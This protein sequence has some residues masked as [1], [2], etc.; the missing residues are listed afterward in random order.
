MKIEKEELA[1]VLAQFNPWWRSEMI[2]DLPSWKR[3]AFGELYRWIVNPPV[4]RATFI[5]GARQVGKTTLIMQA[6]DNL[7][8]DG[9]PAGNIFYATFDHP[10]LKL[11]GIDAAL[12][13]WRQREPKKDGVEYIFLDEAQFIRDWGTF[14]KHQVDFFKQRRIVFTG[15]ATPILQNDQESGVGR[16]HTIRL[17]TMSFYEYIQIKK[18]VLPQLPQIKSLKEIFDWQINEIYHTGDI[19]ASYVAHFHEYLVRGG[20]PQTALVETVNQSQKLLREDIID[21]ALKRDMTAMF[22]V[23]LVLEL[24]QTFLYLCLHDGA[25][26]D[27]ITLCSEL[28]VKRPTAQKFI[29]LLEAAHLIYK[30]Q[31]FG[32][33]KEI[34]RGKHKIYL[35]DPAIAPAVMLKGRSIIDNPESL[36][37][38]AESG[39]LNH[40]FSR[41]YSQNIRFSYWQGKKNLEVDLVAEINNEVIPFEVKYRSQHSSLKDCQG[42]L[43]FCSKRDIKRGY[44]IT[45]SADDFGVIEQKDASLPSILRIPATLLCY[46]MGEMEISQK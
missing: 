35:S 46:F 13:A 12:E 32:Y 24:E 31:P 6:I 3:A 27:M 28:G 25:I 18:L 23:R 16:W 22:G 38:A 11:A 43:Q 8:K 14:V 30:L 4:V 21:K 7:I 26:L 34:L 37:I 33:G 36:S 45:K 5:S 15:S 42:L 2:A 17:T 1:A 9:V 41:Y 39:V 29:E 44:I 20:F 40:L 10:L 19:A